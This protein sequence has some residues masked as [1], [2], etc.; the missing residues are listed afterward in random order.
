M[1]KILV[2]VLV[3]TNCMTLTDYGFEKKEIHFSENQKTSKTLLLNLTA[4][5]EKDA[6]KKPYASSME[7]GIR[8]DYKEKILETDLFKE[9]HTGLGKADIKLYMH[10]TNRGFNNFWLNF[11]SGY[12]LL[13][14]PSYVN[15]DLEIEFIFK[16]S[17]DKTLK[18][19][20][21]KIRHTTFVH[22]ILLPITPFKFMLYEYSQGYKN[23]IDSVFDEAIRDGVF[24]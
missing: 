4:E 21:R 6:E 23:T 13:L 17:K 12:S 20:R 19:Y 8:N 15:D 18:E 5:M 24:K 2:I 7:E 11:L 10:I 9:I 16:D 3:F 22:L 1:K 14:I